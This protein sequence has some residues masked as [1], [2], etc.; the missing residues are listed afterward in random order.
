MKTKQNLIISKRDANN[1]LWGNDSP[2]KQK[3][4]Q[5]K[6]RYKRKAKFKKALDY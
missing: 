2:F 3:V 6:K 5:D 1:I 4:V